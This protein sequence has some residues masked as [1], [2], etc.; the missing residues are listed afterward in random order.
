MD[1]LRRLEQRHNDQLRH[2]Q[3]Q[4][5]DQLRQLQQQ[6]QQQ[7]HEQK[8]QQQGQYYAQQLQLQHIHE[9]FFEHN[10]V[11]IRREQLR[12]QTNY[13]NRQYELLRRWYIDDTTTLKRQG[14]KERTHQLALIRYVGY[15][16]FC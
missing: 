3:L 11:T 13:N 8:L 5:E 12:L 2:V 15:I 10:H 7:Q 4:H 16:P 6:Q 9:V 14:E 1:E